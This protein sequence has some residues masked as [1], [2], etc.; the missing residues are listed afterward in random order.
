MNLHQEFYALREKVWAKFEELVKTGCDILGDFPIV[1][2]EMRVRNSLVDDVEEI[3]IWG[4]IAD[5]NYKLHKGVDLIVG[6]GKIKV[7]CKHIL[8]K[9]EEI[10]EV[11]PNIEDLQTL[12]TYVSG[13][14]SVYTDQIKRGYERDSDKI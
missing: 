13:G 9:T 6:T 8:N 7:I 5:S 3:T 12:S 10:K 2:G 1:V 11:E 14:Y 4:I